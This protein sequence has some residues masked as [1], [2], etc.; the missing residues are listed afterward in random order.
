M[1]DEID[2]PLDVSDLS[3]KFLKTFKRGISI[4]SLDPTELE[5]LSP[6]ERKSDDVDIIE[7]SK[8]ASTNV[9]PADGY[10]TCRDCGV[11]NGVI[12]DTSQ[13]WRFYGA[14]DNKGNDPAR[15]GMP[16]SDL[17]PDVG[18]GCYIELRGRESFKVKKMRNMQSWSSLSYS[19]SKLMASFSNI[20]AICINAGISACIVEEAKHMYKKVYLM[21]DCKRIKLEVMQAASVQ[22]A[23]KIKGVPRD[24][25]ELALLFNIKLKDMRRGSKLFEEVWYSNI[26]NELDVAKNKSSEESSIIDSISLQKDTLNSEST[27]LE[28]SMLKPSNSIDYL[29]RACS[30]L[31]LSES[32]YQICKSLCEYIEDNDLLIKHI[33]ISRTA[34]CLYMTCLAMKC[35]ITFSQ[36]SE[37]CD[38]SE[39]TIKKCYQK[40]TLY[41]EEL[42]ANTLL[43]CTTSIDKV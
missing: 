9:I 18:N 40:M 27:S 25:A 8:C 37:I 39:V 14:E 32:V 11:Q 42:Q 35:N 3:T 2:I 31:E 22:W 19:D 29:H 43:Q 28:D 15:C 30:R 36:I 17:L 1:T 12:I 41:K 4:K 7:C 10:Y 33:P 34:A 23:C 38:I 26:I 5:T 13:E 20:S 16:T 21:K 6:H 24:I